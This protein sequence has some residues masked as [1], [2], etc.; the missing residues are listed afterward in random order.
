MFNKSGKSALKSAVPQY[1]EIVGLAAAKFFGTLAAVSPAALAEARKQSNDGFDPVIW[2]LPQKAFLDKTFRP[3]TFIDC[4][5]P[6]DNEKIYNTQ[7]KSTSSN[8]CKDYCDYSLIEMNCRCTWKD[9]ISIRPTMTGKTSTDSRAISFAVNEKWH[10]ITFPVEEPLIGYHIMEQ[11]I[12]FVHKG[13]E[14]F[15]G[16]MKDG[17]NTMGLKITTKDI[18]NDVEEQTINENDVHEV[19]D[20]GSWKDHQ[21]GVPGAG[22]VRK[23]GKII[24]PNKSWVD[25]ETTYTAVHPQQYHEWT[26]HSYEITDPTEK[27]Q[28]TILGLDFG[29]INDILTPYKGLISM[30]VSYSAGGIQTDLQFSNRQLGGNEIALLKEQT[31][32]RLEPILALNR[33]GRTF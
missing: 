21:P 16:H 24:V 23:G 26:D 6:N 29:E 9:W 32:H 11:K 20:N 10:S 12:I 15:F 3:P 8:E 33:F 14:Y 4:C 2:I 22:K 31:F 18:T 28:C 1:Q 19:I 13:I 27:F 7:K 5:Q 30:Q 17:G 25:G